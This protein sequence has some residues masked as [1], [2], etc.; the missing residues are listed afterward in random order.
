MAETIYKKRK[1]MNDMYKKG[2]YRFNKI[3]IY[4]S[5][6]IMVVAFF[7]YIS[8]ES[9]LRGGLVNDLSEI[10][11]GINRWSI[12]SIYPD[13]IR[14]VWIYVTLSFPVIALW[15]FVTLDFS[16]EYYESVLASENNFL[17]RVVGVLV[18]MLV[19]FFILKLILF[20]EFFGGSE[21]FK[22]GPIKNPT[23]TA[24]IYGGSYIGATIVSGLF[25]LSA[26]AS[27]S[28]GFFNLY[29][30]FITLIKRK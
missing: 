14:V 12:G 2:F 7:A 28:I 4:W 9:I 24:S 21:I 15:S 16:F 1:Y 23:F 30:I 22:D 10:T 20:C 8:P 19:C 5:V 27:L 11:V 3:F 6:S 26:S 13:K 29:H 25:A 17:K 18:V